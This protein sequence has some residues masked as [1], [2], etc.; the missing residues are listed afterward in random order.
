MEIFEGKMTGIRFWSRALT[1]L[2]VFAIY[3]YGKTPDYMNV[4][5]I[6]KIR[7]EA[8]KK[9]IFERLWRHRWK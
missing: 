3:M 4:Y 5:E 8:E 6:Y 7:K 2:E 1:S 9:N